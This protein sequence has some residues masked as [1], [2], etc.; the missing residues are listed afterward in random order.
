MASFCTNNCAASRVK[1]FTSQPRSQD[2]Q[3]SERV[4]GNLSTISFDYFTPS[5]DWPPTV[6]SKFRPG[7]QG[8]WGPLKRN[9]K[10]RGIKCVMSQG[11]E[12]NQVYS[13]ASSTWYF[14]RERV[15]PYDKVLYTMWT[16]LLLDTKWKLT[17]LREGLMLSSELNQE[18]DY[19]NIAPW[20]AVRLLETKILILPSQTT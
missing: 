11:Y 10:H 6:R 4:W 20:T 1:R 7:S 13:K 15:N 17:W 5:E 12:Y 3:L 14:H 18:T 19:R 8:G 9:F 2:S 16:H